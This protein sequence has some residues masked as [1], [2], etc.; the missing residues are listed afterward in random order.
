MN[1]HAIL[2]QVV[3]GWVGSRL[4]SLV[5]CNRGVDGFLSSVID[6]WLTAV[7]TTMDLPEMSPEEWSF[8]EDLPHS[9]GSD[10]AIPASLLDG[11]DVSVDDYADGR[12]VV[13]DCLFPAE[14]NDEIIADHATVLSRF[15]AS[16]NPSR[17][18]FIWEKGGFMSNIFGKKQKAVDLVFG[19]ASGTKRPL[20]PFCNDFDEVDELRMENSQCLHPQGA[21]W[22]SSQ[23]FQP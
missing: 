10:S 1:V 23:P 8:L 18:K 21:C 5:D 3:G 2:C 7:V 14:D 15:D 20:P 9:V 13:T 11:S 6:W 12:R 19:A 4:F 22:R 17:P 16:L